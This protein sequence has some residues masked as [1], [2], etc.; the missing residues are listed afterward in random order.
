MYDPDSAAPIIATPAGAQVQKELKPGQK[1]GIPG[2]ANG[3]E[4]AP[5][6][7]DKIPTDGPALVTAQWAGAVRMK[8]QSCFSVPPGVDR[9][10]KSCEVEWE[11]LRD[12]T[13]R[14]ARVRRSSGVAALDSCALN[15][16]MMA[17]KVEPLPPEIDAMSVWTSITFQ[18]GL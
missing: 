1:A 6:P 11:V 12:G 7:I 16:V 13:I 14:N 15:A 10:D 4:G 18:F 3:V 5:M 9:P 8:I 17:A 2:I